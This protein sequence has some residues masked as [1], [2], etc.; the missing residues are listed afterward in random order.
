MKENELKVKRL[1]VTLKPDN[2][3]VLLRPFF[4]TSDERA[5]KI[6]GRI[7]SL[8][9]VEAEN[10]QKKILKE[11]S[12]GHLNL[13]ERFLKRYAEVK[14]LSLIDDEPSYSRKFIIGSYFI[15]EYAL[16]ASALFNPS[17]VLHPD[18]S[19]LPEGSKRYIISLRATGEGH[20]SSI[21]FR[22]CVIDREGNIEMSPLTKFVQ[23]PEP[24]A[25][26]YFDK[27]I[28]SMKL[29]ELNLSCE[30]TGNV[31]ADLGK[32]FSLDELES[33]LKEEML[34]C[35]GQAEDFK[36]IVEDVRTLARS[37]FR[38]SFS[39]IL[40]LSEKVI[41]PHSPNQ[42]KGIE[43]ARFVRFRN[44]DGSSQYYATFTAYD[45]K[46]IFPQLLETKDF[47]NFH[48]MTLNGQAV[49]NKGMALFPRKVNGKFLMLSRQDNENIYLMSSDNI[50]FWHDAQKI[51][52]PNSLWQYVQV[53]N[54]GSPIELPEGWLVLNHGVGPVREYCIGAFLLDLDDP[55]KII[56]RL[57]KPLIRSETEEREGYVPNVV[58]SC[59]AVVHNEL[60]FIP[61][62]YSDY[63][64]RFATINLAELLE[65]MI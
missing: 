64:T 26:Q 65:K 14:H 6:M 63:A 7:M 12:S 39:P 23:D 44:D 60:L 41:F 18:Q 21:S 49:Q 53:G 55:T 4:P 15:S 46:A 57:K 61:Y 50:H 29:F 17:I 24:Q 28:F 59:G 33:S 16:E 22:G 38:V 19:E 27:K 25:N 31:L 42:R 1:P 34:R 5:T 3:R 2:T 8:T 52:K 62:G 11:F 30:F 47:Q 58:Y 45:G 51:L 9:E 36:W 48:I 35:R 32:E 40:K 13:E 20:I 37:N 54:C 10:L 43:D 56:G